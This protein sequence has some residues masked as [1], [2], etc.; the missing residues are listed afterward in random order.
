MSGTRFSM[1]SF[2]RCV[3]FRNNISLKRIDVTISNNLV[4]PESGIMGAWIGDIPDDPNNHEQRGTWDF[5]LAQLDLASAPRSRIM[6][7]TCLENPICY[8]VSNNEMCKTCKHTN[9]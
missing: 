5:K 8:I 4:V 7:S 6:R 3:H 9:R 2:P 1:L